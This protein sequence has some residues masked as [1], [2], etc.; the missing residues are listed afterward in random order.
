M[1]FSNTKRREKP[2]KWY[3]TNVYPMKMWKFERETEQNQRNIFS[4][5]VR[6]NLRNY[7]TVKE[8]KSFFS[9][10]SIKR[11][12]K[13]NFREI[14]SF[15]SDFVEKRFIVGKYILKKLLKKW[16]KPKKEKYFMC[17]WNNKKN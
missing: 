15:V 4:E 9:S 6:F 3:F 12:K 8:K 11:S 16:N 5:R 10:P 13:E 2:E 7:L 14:F 17:G 1:I